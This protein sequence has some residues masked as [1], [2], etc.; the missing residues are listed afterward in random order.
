MAS[1]QHP[2]CQYTRRSAAA[3]IPCRALIGRPRRPPAFGMLTV[4]AFITS[5]AAT[6]FY[7]Q[8][9]SKLYNKILYFLLHQNGS[10]LTDVRERCAMQST[11]KPSATEKCS[12]HESTWHF[13][14]LPPLFFQNLTLKFVQSLHFST[15]FL[16]PSCSRSYCNVLLGSFCSR[17]SLLALEE[18]HSNVYMSSSIMTSRILAHIGQYLKEINGIRPVSKGNI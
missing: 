14:T 10:D 7:K 4:T 9:K 16:D 6:P 1:F 5:A 2:C 12:K 13:H 17:Y 18:S 15:N 11:L 3:S 8:I